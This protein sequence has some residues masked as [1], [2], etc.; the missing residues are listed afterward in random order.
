MIERVPSDGV[1]WFDEMV[2]PVCNDRLIERSLIQGVLLPGI[3]NS[4]SYAGSVEMSSTN[5]VWLRH[6]DKSVTIHDRALIA[7]QP[8][9]IG[10][11]VVISY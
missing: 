1:S 10:D 6:D 4:Q 7:L 3:G 9:N 5:F 2:L 11:R 8:F